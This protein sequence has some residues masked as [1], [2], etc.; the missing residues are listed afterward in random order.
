MD[1]PTVI[2]KEHRATYYLLR[3]AVIAAGS[4]VMS[5]PLLSR[6][7]DGILPP[8]IS[9][10]WYY[11][12][13]IAFVMGMAAAGC[14]LAIIR[15][16]TASEQSL[17]NL[18]GG[19]ALVV[20]A[21]ACWPKTAAGDPLGPDAYPEEVQTANTINLV[22]L[23]VL[24]IA[25]AVVAARVPADLINA[26]RAHRTEDP[27]AQGGAGGARVILRVIELLCPLVVGGA[28][29]WFILDTETVARRAHG[30]AAVLLFLCLGV[31]AFLRTPPGIS[32]LRWLDDVPVGDSVVPSSSDFS[33][34]NGRR[35]P[36]IFSAIY[37][38]VAVGMLT[39]V[40]FAF[41]MFQLGAVSEWIIEI[42]FALLSLFL[43]FWVAQTR[44]AW[45]EE[46][47]SPSEREF[48]LGT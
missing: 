48:A 17:L 9:D 42:E 44:D 45:M 34:A 38:V 14:L 30:S 10:S 37:S 19:C 32:V 35:W 29:V 36:R 33:L 41:V 40:G 3:I 4:L 1:R 2:R 27:P 43:V 21:A 13:Q 5:A 6:I 15:G 31:V 11:D 7:G 24:V 26:G 8:S 20:G 39:V 22:A 16:N 12:G 25:A 18:A 46:T 23:I 47:P 28:I